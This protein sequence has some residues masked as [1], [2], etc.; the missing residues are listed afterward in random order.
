MIEF[1]KVSTVNVNGIRSAINKGLASWIASTQPDVICLQEIKATEEQ[2]PEE[3]TSLGYSMHWHPAQKKGYSGVAILSKQE[4]LRVVKGMDVNWIDEEGRVIMAEFENLIVFSVYAPSGTTGDERQQMKYKFL[5]DYQKFALEQSKQNKPVIFA[6]DFNIAH[7]EVD[8]HNPVSN[9]NSSGF[10]PEERA[11]FS[12]HLASGFVDVFREHNP[13]TKDEY[14]WWSFRAGS[15]ARNKGWR[16]DYQLA[17]PSLKEKTKEA[18]IE[19]DVVLSDHAPVTAVY[20][21]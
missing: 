15:R 11:W 5:A 14:S 4:P 18:Y 10:L 16:I 17:S 12:Q 21:L 8:I 6:G 3:I 9:K 20:A 7:Q 2:V 19:T 1:I 13:H